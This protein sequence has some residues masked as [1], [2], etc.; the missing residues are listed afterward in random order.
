MLDLRFIR[1][2]PELVKAGIARKNDQSDIDAI[3]KLDERRREIIRQ[4]ESKK[5]EKN[6]ASGEI[7][8]KKKAGESAD[9]AIA[10]MRQLGDDITALDNDLR[11]LESDLKIRLDWIPNIPHESVPVGTDESANVVVREWGEIPKPSFEVKPHWEIGEKLGILDLTT[12]ANLS[13][14]GF[15]LLR[16][17]GARLQ[18]ALINYMLDTHISNGFTEVAPP[19][20]VTADT[21][22]GTGQ[23]PK[24]ADDMYRIEADDMY[25]IPTAEVPITNMYKQTILDYKD[26]P[27]YMVGYTPCFRREAGAAGKDTRGMIRLHQFEKVELVKIVRP[28]TSYDELESLLKQAEKVLQGLKIPYRISTLASGDLSFAAAKCY[29]IEL[30]AAGVQKY[31]EISSVSNFEDF[32]ARRMNCRFRDEDRQVKHPHTLNG[33]G[34]ALARLI[35]AILENYQNPDGSVTIPEALRPYMGGMEK[36]G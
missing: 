2:N 1:E 9:D 5:A 28:E 15:S 31:L 32:Q 11:D 4:V 12:A 10:A 27:L 8:K 25:L 35:P 16:G 26:L 6:K 24:L 23:L 29:D 34:T 20:I 22:Y 13:G 30:W 18:R 17:A 36:I 7:A 3:L 14:S 21:M 33:S 19:F